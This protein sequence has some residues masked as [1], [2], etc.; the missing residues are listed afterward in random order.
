MAINGGKVKPNN[1]H[2]ATSLRRASGLLLQ[3]KPFNLDSTACALRKEGL[4]NHFAIS[5][6]NPFLF[7]RQTHTDL[8]RTATHTDLCSTRRRIPHMTSS[9]QNTQ[10]S[11]QYSKLA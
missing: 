7:S 8:H 3:K 9:K 4:L 11:R 6:R 10:R 2:L 5:R 1:Q